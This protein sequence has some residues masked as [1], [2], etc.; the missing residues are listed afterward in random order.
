MEDL[1]IIWN[2]VPHEVQVS[3]SL[4]IIQMAIYLPVMKEECFMRWV[5]THFV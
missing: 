3:D 2:Y 4:L 5:I 1:L